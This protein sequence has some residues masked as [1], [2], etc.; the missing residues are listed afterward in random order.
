[1]GDE[2]KITRGRPQK[3]VTITRKAIEDKRQ[4]KL[5]SKKENTSG[6]SYGE[7]PQQNIASIL[8]KM[9]DRMETMTEEI[10]SVKEELR[11][12]RREHA[13]TIDAIKEISIMSDEI[14]G[15]ERRWA[16]ERKYLTERIERLEK[17]EENRERKEKKLNVVIKG[18]DIKG[19]VEEIQEFMKQK[20]KVD[21]K[22][23]DTQVIKTI[24]SNKIIKV[25]L[26]D[27]ESKMKI[28]ENKK[29]LKEE[30]IFI[31]D[32]L[33]F[34]QREIQ[35]KIIKYA[36]EQKTLGKRVKVGYRKFM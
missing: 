13:E 32:D 9:M 21:I 31:D 11:K 17:T 36:E 8:N 27:W 35:R 16:E 30:K 14:E 3:N 28:R 5:T 22:I 25:K 10:K 12:V 24:N 7:D 6:N 29:L 15:K 26:T 4:T 1:M 23:E 34:T 18:I 33:T 2:G 20:L 19:E